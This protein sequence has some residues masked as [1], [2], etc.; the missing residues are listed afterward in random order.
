M[1]KFKGIQKIAM[2]AMLISLSTVIGII[3]KNL[4]SIGMYYR[5]TFE[6][7]PIIFA[8][9]TLGPVY[10]AVIGFASD[11]ISCICSVN[12]TV[13]P[14]I[15]I[16]AVCVGLFSG[17]TAKIFKKAS[18]NKK[19]ALSAAFGHLIGQ[20]IIKSF[21]KIIYFGMPLWGIAIGFVISAI[22]CT[23]EILVIKVLL[24]NKSV[25]SYMEKLK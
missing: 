8:S 11:F 24:N 23:F 7:L 18:L 15:S 19:V 5:I 17:V 21:A 14:I 25:C 12:P 16:G 20:I 4:F 22:V 1:R 6:N 2:S 10:G 3:C 13:N 9:I